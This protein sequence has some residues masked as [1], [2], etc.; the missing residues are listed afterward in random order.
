MQKPRPRESDL[1]PGHRSG[2]A[3]E[4][5]YAPAGFGE[6]AGILGDVLTLSGGGGVVTRLAASWQLEEKGAWGDLSCCPELGVRLQS[7]PVSLSD[8]HLQGQTGN[9][10]QRE[11]ETFSLYINQIY[12]DRSQTRV[13]RSPLAV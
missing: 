2:V 13:N 9:N 3:S 6:Q 11:R 10:G 7:L 4:A 12:T 5:S 8:G 1:R